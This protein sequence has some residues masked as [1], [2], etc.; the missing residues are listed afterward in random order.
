MK[1]GLILFIAMMM[2]LLSACSGK[3]E[4]KS[5]DEQANAGGDSGELVP[6]EGAK[7]KLW[8]V[9]NKFTE[10]AI[11]EFEKQYKVE[12]EL[13]D[14]FYTET[15]P[16]LKTDGPAGLGADVLAFGH[17]RVGDAAKS[18]L[19]LPNDYFEEETKANTI[20]S[21]IDA[22]TYN[23]ILY[24]YPQYMYTYAMYVNRDI[25]GDA[26]LDTWDE[27][28]D[29]AKKYN[30]IPNNKYGFMMETNSLYDVNSF[31]AG[32]GG[33]VFGKNGT[34]KNDLGINSEGSVKG[35]E[36]FKSLKQILPI[37]NTEI[38]RDV[39]TSL[40][41]DGKV[42]LNID[43]T[44]NAASYKDVSFDMDVVPLPE[45]PGGK[46]PLA[47]SGI[48]GIYVSAYT[49]YPNASKLFAHFMASKE[50]QIKSAQELGNIPVF[51]GVDSNLPEF[52]DNKLM[53][54]FIKQ[55]Q[56]TTPMPNLPEMEYYWVNVEPAL[57]RIWNG[58]DIK[59]TLDQAQ[60]KMKESI[61]AGSK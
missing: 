57:E 23:N 9:K 3:S 49:K 48:S 36:F 61:E 26:K 16:R 32:Y 35:M 17:D 24:G 52:K 53:Q 13:E 44:F 14:V 21:A 15:L 47:Y 60:S 7:L 18:G 41:H 30:D 8:T 33:Y 34:D 55:S 38:T 4:K 27:V 42:A 12:V 2:L 37:K 5:T 40:F 20:P 6:E 11:A 45:M 59:K 56:Y 10:D 54:G 46:R 50:N 58:S 39:K 28:M 43:G 25:V 51:K 31:M 22:V 19:I 29:I 1:K